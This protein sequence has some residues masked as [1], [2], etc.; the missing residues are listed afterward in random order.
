MSI[1]FNM[2]TQS[3]L[4][5]KEEDYCFE[6]VGWQAEGRQTWSIGAGNYNEFVPKAS[7]DN[8]ACPLHAVLKAACFGR[9]GSGDGHFAWKA[10]E[11]ATL[12]CTLLTTV[13]LHNVKEARTSCYTSNHSLLRLISCGY[14]DWKL[15]ATH[16]RFG[17]KE[18][19]VL[20]ACSVDWL[21]GGQCFLKANVS[22][23]KALLKAPANMY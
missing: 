17:L 22:D 15:C 14:D 3:I 16:P 23:F 19:A 18:I 5:K 13:G 20:H 9:V 7:P 4:L 2:H 6:W 8:G 10:M 12:S 1:Y 11:T 21:Q